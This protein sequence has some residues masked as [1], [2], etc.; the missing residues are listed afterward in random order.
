MEV[1]Q[2]YKKILE[3]KHAKYLELKRLD[4]IRF[5]V[6]NEKRKCRDGLSDRR[7]NVEKSAT[8]NCSKSNKKEN[9]PAI[10]K[11]PDPKFF[12]ASIKKSAKC[13]S[14]YNCHFVDASKL[15]SPEPTSSSESKD[16]SGSTP[17]TSVSSTC[18]SCSSKLNFIPGDSGS[19]HSDEDEEAGGS[20]TEVDL[21]VEM[22]E[23]E[24]EE[25]GLMDG[26]GFDVAILEEM[27]EYNPLL[28]RSQ[29]SS[30]GSSGPDDD[31]SLVDCLSDCHES[32]D[33][34]WMKNSGGSESLSEETSTGEL[35]DLD[36][37]QLDPGNGQGLDLESEPGLK[38]PARHFSGTEIPS[39]LKKSASKS[40][41][42]KQANYEDFG[43]KSD[44]RKTWKSLSTFRKNLNTIDKIN[45]ENV[46]HSEM[47]QEFENLALHHK[48][49]SKNVAKS[50]STEGF[51][52]QA[53]GIQARYL[54]V[55]DKYQA[56][57]GR[58]RKRSNYD[59]ESSSNNNSEDSNDY[60]HSEMDDHFDLQGIE[61]SDDAAVEEDDED[62]DSDSGSQ[63][64]VNEMDNLKQYLY[65]QDLE[66]NEVDSDCPGDEGGGDENVSDAGFGVE[67]ASMDEAEC[68]A[69]DEGG[70]EGEDNDNEKCDGNHDDDEDEDDDEGEEETELEAAEMAAVEMEDDQ[71]LLDMSN[72]NE[73]VNQSCNHL[74]HFD[75]DLNN[76]ADN[77]YDDSL[78]LSLL[79]DEKVTH[80]EC[81]YQSLKMRES[82]E[83]VINSNNYGSLD[84][85][86][87][88]GNVRIGSRAQWFKTRKKSAKTETSIFSHSNSLG[89][90]FLD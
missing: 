12:P 49:K 62:D 78:N 11:K 80:T 34:A 23:I 3:D 58:L 54:Y 71:L 35:V 59:D 53:P 89:Q 44:Y 7:S 42:K 73:T 68:D 19:V 15:K 55:Q 40:S 72:E 75:V 16:L 43:L 2:S 77:V 46:C 50:N 21:D 39:A 86:E 9:R 76:L 8:S 18:S 25:I 6:E 38:E 37:N 22:A 4:E 84:R 64:S 90:K 83:M 61:I 81:L 66:A 1:D 36:K 88:V 5:K 48:R 24:D 85:L 56:N 70:E 79:P 13:V 10:P 52:G 27:Q 45:E 60:L 33:L 31:E 57:S 41:I 63:G 14:I 26:N 47:C 29:A 32:D 20:D 30:Y 82:E 74:H 28:A 65:F 69:D 87:N 51:R 17:Y 67:N